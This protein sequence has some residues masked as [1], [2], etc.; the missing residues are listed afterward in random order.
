MATM[1][2]SFT[3]LRDGDWGV[4]APAG[5]KRGDIL[6]VRKRD[7]SISTVEVERVLWT[8]NGIALC[9]IY[10]DRPAY[11]RSSGSGRSG[12][13]RSG[14]CA[15][16]GGPVRDAAH[17]RAMEGYCGSCAFDEFDC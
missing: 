7:G 16:C 5:T 9:S 4:R 17:H 8:G 2:A 10:D 13:R 6:D 11:R 1:T 14:G 12:G 15:G 3:K